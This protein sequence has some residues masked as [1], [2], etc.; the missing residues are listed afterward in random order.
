MPLIQP[1]SAYEYILSTA[2]EINLICRPLL[3]LN[4]S[5]FAYMKIFDG[6]SYLFL[7]NNLEFRKAFFNNIK[8][9]GSY[10]TKL[11]S[12]YSLEGTIKSKYRYYLSPVQLNQFD[13]KKD[14]ILYLAY[15]FNIWNILY[16]TS[17]NIN[18]QERYIFA[19]TNKDTFFSEF[20]L[21][22]LPLLEHFI[23]YFREK[24]FYLID[25]NDIKKLC[26]FEQHFNFSHFSK[27]QRN[28]REVQ[29]FLEETKLKNQIIRGKDKE[30]LLS[31]R[32][33]ECLEY[34]SYGYSAKE[35]GKSLNL[36]PR[37]IEYYLQNTKRRTGYSSREEVLSHFAKSNKVNNIISHKQRLYRIDENND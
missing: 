21:K 10:L 4:I 37:T 12:N 7:D 27:E 3:W 23:D 29:Q 31:K 1:L 13:F 30:I 14:P 16:I 26:Y 24:A 9:L 6:G 28:F 18:Y 8:N 33:V 25:T 17:N 2:E 32:E 22:N 5:Y 35:I 15:D 11:S 34:L 20:Y 19:Q 36:S